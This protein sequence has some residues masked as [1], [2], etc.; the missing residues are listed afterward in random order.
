M[1]VWRY[2]DEAIRHGWEFLDLAHEKD[3]AQLFDAIKN[4]PNGFEEFLFR[5]QMAI[6]NLVEATPSRRPA[7]LRRLAPKDELTQLALILGAWQHCR[8][9]VLA[10]DWL[11]DHESR[12]TPGRPYRKETAAQGLLFDDLRKRAITRWPFQW[13]TSPFSKEAARKEPWEAP[14]Y[15]ETMDDYNPETGFY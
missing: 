15:N 7:Q 13:G 14:D 12:F 9:A 5:N 3:K 10:Y 2:R 8:K 4:N 6:M 1:S 11:M